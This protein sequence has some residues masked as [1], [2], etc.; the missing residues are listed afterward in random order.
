MDQMLQNQNPRIYKLY[1]LLVSSLQYLASC[2]QIVQ[3][4]SPSKINTLCKCTIVP[5]QADKNAR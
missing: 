3:T 1:D 2:I 4:A 5:T